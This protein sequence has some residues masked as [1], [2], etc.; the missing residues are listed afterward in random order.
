MNNAAECLP[1]DD[2]MFKDAMPGETVLKDGTFYVRE[3]DWIKFLTLIA[4]KTL[5]KELADQFKNYTNQ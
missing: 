5:P 2:V 3:S 4:E 1:D